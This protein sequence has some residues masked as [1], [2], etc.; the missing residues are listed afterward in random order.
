MAMMAING[1]KMNVIQMN[2][3]GEKT[4]V[5]IHGLFTSLSV[6]YFHIAP[7]LAKKY[8]VVLY[9]LSGHGLSEPCEEELLTPKNMSRELIALMGA[10]KIKQAHLVGY[11]FGGSV[12][13]FTACHHPNLVKRLTLIDMPDFNEEA[14]TQQLN[15]TTDFDFEQ[16]IKSYLQ[17][18]TIP[19]PEQVN[20]RTMARLK[21]MFG[22]GKLTKMLAAS[23]QLLADLPLTQ[24][25][26][27]TLLL[28]GKKSPYLATGK[29]LKR[30]I[31]HA[32][33]QIGKGDHNI[34]VQSTLWVYWKLRIFSNKRLK[35][36]EQNETR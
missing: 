10:L 18:T 4:I 26:T 17:S 6:Y 34:P 19:I 35:G 14:F 21:T 11:S 16:E 23:R 24:L 12:A 15:N 25:T 22:D 1:K 31:P 29:K 27:P 8:H 5:M 32:R 9:D 20:Q 2:P 13:L 3:N 36:Y 7:R 28:Y 30:L 33:L